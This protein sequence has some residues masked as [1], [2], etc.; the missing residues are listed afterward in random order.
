MT[1]NKNDYLKLFAI[2]M[3]TVLL[4]FSILELRVALSGSS[5]LAQ[6][7]P[8]TT[9]TPTPTHPPSATPTATPSPIPLPIGTVILT[10]FMACPTEGNEWIELYNTS[11]STIQVTNWQIID[12]ANNKKTITGTIAPYSFSAF[13]WSGSL[14]NNAGDS[15]KV[16]TSTGQT[17]AEASYTKCTPGISFVYENGEWTGALPSPNQETEVSENTKPTATTSAYVT[18]QSLDDTE[19]NFLSNLNAENILSDLSSLPIPYQMPN[20]NTINSLEDNV[21]TSNITSQQ[22]KSS[23][24]PA[25]GVILGGMLQLLSGSYVLYDTYFKNHS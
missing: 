4:Y 22:Q 5:A 8:C 25:I 20:I 6:T 24:T 1:Y 19:Q 14:L 7:L 18:S 3:S 11:S 17:L 2:L 13:E 12:A 16:I 15:F 23:N 10:E 21:S 9:P